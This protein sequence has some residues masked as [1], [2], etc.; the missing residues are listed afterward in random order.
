MNINVNLIIVIG[1]IYFLV[2][3][4]LVW[5]SFRNEKMQKIFSTIFFC[6]YLGVLIA[7]VLSVIKIENNIVNI[8]FDFSGD[9]YAK[10]IKWSFDNISQF[11]LIINLVMLVPLG[12][13]LS[14]L[15]KKKKPLAKILILIG[16]GLLTGFLIEGCQ[17]ILPVPRSVQL[18]DVMLNMASTLI[19]GF[20]GQIYL[21][22]IDKIRKT[23]NN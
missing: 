20:I 17:F 7:G 5:A 8:S 16:F 23:T 14:L 10:D 12:L 18:S 6:L 22:I 13:F 19:G 2:I 1:V 3:P 15:S 4:F 11:D 9:W 21:F